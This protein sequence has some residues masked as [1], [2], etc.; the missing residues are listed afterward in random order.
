M[1]TKLVNKRLRSHTNIRT[2]AASSRHIPYTRM[3]DHHTIKTR[4]G[5][6]MQVLAIEGWPFET[7]DN[8][9]IDALKA[10]KNVVYRGIASPTTGVYTHVVRRKSK[11]SLPG[12]IEDV[13]GAELNRKYKKILSSRTLYENALYLTI[14]ERPDFI[15]RSKYKVVNKEND[16]HKTSGSS[17]TGQLKKL[18]VVTGASNHKKADVE[19]INELALLDE[20]ILRRLNEKSSLL[21][22]NLAQYGVRRLGKDLAP[23]GL[24]SEPLSF[25]YELINGEQRPVALPQQS[26][27]DYLP[28]TRL[29]F[30]R[31][32]LHHLRKNHAN[33]FCL[34]QQSKSSPA[35]FR[36]F[37]AHSA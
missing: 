25:L 22:E 31:D 12:G 37:Y 18:K 1:P 20:Q 30:G 23:N 28:S 27:G 11:A 7:T 32:S 14:I 10:L 5:D 35:A 34:S 17:V 4:D 8:D 16:K 19:K 9:Q 2:E 3:V 21:V 6:M 33:V 15:M 26:L 13:F 36:A 24:L 29:I